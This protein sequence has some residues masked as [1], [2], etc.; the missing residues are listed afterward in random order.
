MFRPTIVKVFATLAKNYNNAPCR[1]EKNVK[2]ATTTFSHG[3]IMVYQN[4][5]LSSW[6]TEPISELIIWI[7]L[8]PSLFTAGQMIFQTVGLW[9]LPT[10]VEFSKR[11]VHLLLIT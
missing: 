5:P 1:M 11:Y 4:I 6:L 8:G 2:C 10:L 7:S 9:W 3:R